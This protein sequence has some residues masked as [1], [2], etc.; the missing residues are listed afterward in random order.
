MSWFL[1]S[2]R[3]LKLFYLTGKLLFPYKYHKKCG[4]VLYLQGFLSVALIEGTL[5]CGPHS[6]F[7]FDGDNNTPHEL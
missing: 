7:V 3:L 1:I 6:V 4:E 5:Q 2:F